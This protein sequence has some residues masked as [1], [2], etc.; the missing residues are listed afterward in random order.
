MVGRAAICSL[1]LI[2]S[3]SSTSG[4]SRYSMRGEEGR[5]I[6]EPMGDG[7]ETLNTLMGELV[8]KR[9]GMSGESKIVEVLNPSRIPSKISRRLTRRGSMVSNEFMGAASF[10]V[11]LIRSEPG[12]M[13]CR[14][15]GI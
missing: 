1:S 12:V 11:L 3:G 8:C 13:S 10:I 14:I 5:R 15:V 2:G 9:E 7:M 6:G 4:N